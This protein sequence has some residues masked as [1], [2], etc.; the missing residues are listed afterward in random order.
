MRIIVSFLICF[1]FLVST[2]A[3]SYNNEWIDFNKTYYKFPVGSDGIYRISQPSLSTIGLGV[4]PAQNFQ[5]WRNGKEIPLYTS[6]PSGVL[7]SNGYLEFY[8]EMNDGKADKALY[9]Y[10][11]LQIADKW[12]LY[13][14]TA[15]YFLTVNSS[16]A[17]KRYSSISNNVQGNV[18]PPQT[19]FVYT[20][21]KYFRDVMNNGYGVDYGEM[22]YSSSY[23]TGEGWTSQNIAA[24]ASLQMLNSNLYVDHNSADDVTLDVQVAGNMGYLR[25]VRIKLNGTQLAD[26]LVNSY[27]IKRFHITGQPL[28]ILA[29]NNALI[30]VVNGGTGTDKIVVAGYQLTYPRQFNFGG[31]SIFRFN[32][33]AGPEKY[34]EISNF[35]F[36][37]SPPVLLDPV[38]RNRI[39]GD[40]SGS[41]VRFVLPATTA[42]S[43]YVL[44]NVESSNIKYIT[45]FTQRN[46]IDHSLPSMQ[47]NYI[48]ISNPLLFDDGTGHNQVDLYRQYRASAAGGNYQVVVNDINELT[49][50]FAFGIKHHPLAIRNFGYFCMANFTNPP[51]YFLLIGKGLNYKEFRAHESD[52]NISQWA[53]VPTFGYPPSDNL[54]FAQRT[55]S[56]Q[57]VNVGRLSAVTG[58]EVG[59]YLA[60]VKVFEQNQFSG[61]QTIQNKGWMKNVA[62]VT[63]AI[64]D[65]SL[66]ASIN[67]FMAGYA[68]TLVDTF[69]GAKV[70]SFNS[71]SGSY[72]SA[73]SNKTI[74]ELFNGG[75]SF[76]TYFGHSS[77]NTLEFNLDN[78][79]NYSNTG[80]YPLI[81]V[82]GCNTGNLF[83]FDTLRAFNNGTLSEKYVFAKEK[84]SIAFIS[85][86]H[87]GLP[88]QLDYF[89][90]RFNKNLANYMYGSTLGEM[91]RATA[92]YLAINNPNDFATR[93]HA[94][95]ITFH[96]DPAIRLNP[97][98]KPDFVITDSLISI[99]PV[100]ATVADTSVTISVHLFN[101]GKAVSD[102][103]NILVR[104][105][106]PDQ[107]VRLLETRRIPATRYEDVLTFILPVDPVNMSGINKI[108]VSVD[109]ENQV[110]E[111]SESNNTAQTTFEI[112]KD[113]IR[114]VYPYNYAI[115]GNDA[116]LKLYGST[117]NPLEE[118]ETYIMEMDTTR[119]FNSG[120]LIRQSVTDS[121]GIIEFS[122]GVSL[123]DSTVYY[124]RLTT[125]PETG[126]SFWQNSSFTF[127]RNET[128]DGY[129][130]SQFFQHTNSRYND[131]RLDS[132]NRQF[133]FNNKTRKLLIN[134][135]LYPYYLY[136]QIDVNIDND[137]EELYGCVYNSLQFV[138]YNP[139]SLT[140]MKNWNVNATSGR[141]GSAKIC[142][143]S[144]S[145]DDT[146]KF[147]EFNYPTA[148]A[149]E[150]AMNFF[151]SIP[152]GYYV[153]VTNLGRTDN[154]SF[155]DSWKAD[156][157]VLGSGRS[158]WHKFHQMGLHQIDSFTNNKPFLFLF[159][160]GDTINFP[161]RQ[162][163][164][165]AANIHISDTF[166]FP[167]KSVKGSITSPDLGPVKQWKR[168]KWKADPL[169]ASATAYFDLYGID[170]N[171]NQTF[172]RSVKASRD[173]SISFVGATVFPK[174][175]IV[176]NTSDSEN[177]VPVQLKYWMLTGNNYPEGAL[178]PNLLYNCRDT[179]YS[180]DSLYFKVAFKNI[181]DVAF[182]S[183]KLRLTFTSLSG[184]ESLVIDNLQN[185]ARLKPVAPGD[186]AI[187]SYVI[188]LAG[189]PGMNKIKLEVNPDNDQPEQFHFNNVL[190]IPVYVIAGGCIGN[191]VQYAVYP[192][193][194]CNFQWQVNQGA[195]YVN[196]ANAG[197]Y[198]GVTTAQLNISS[199]TSEMAGYRYRCV[200]SNSNEI[201]YSQPFILRFTSTWLGGVSTNWH[202]AGNWSCGVVP[203]TNTDV[204]VKSGT[205]YQP[206]INSNAGCHSLNLYDAATLKIKAGFELQV[207][208]K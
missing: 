195:G 90:S 64:S 145:V 180:S 200:T 10:D 127:I 184:N 150:A 113:A 89:T 191:D 205:T 126:S 65:P 137:K 82:N 92:Q 79:Q 121:G 86:T 72:T 52:P 173:T 203:N 155:I 182:D 207:N 47:G 36:G 188:P 12:S 4:V 29:S 171:Q 6:V 168:F 142:L 76:L 21:Q 56:F 11:S 94:E 42:A 125:S 164:G 136:D 58:K 15:M 119:L 116:S 106:L 38:N 33:P 153:S 27:H 146:R 138:L 177:A 75:L 104:H 175:K 68:N 23:E 111:L 51:Q 147:F 99:S 158:L 96:G 186:T 80:K 178:A 67:F 2:H 196:L 148:S 190:Q 160:K 28:S 25:Y 124:W 102:S 103:I 201:I 170:D 39:V 199:P 20:L 206:V 208:G 163:V 46:F 101:I 132:V 197:K 154:T 88:Q 129:A 97:F 141:F 179:L 134:T 139:V 204:I 152:N 13:T 144:S 185:G 181:S 55:Q 62:Q 59:D 109:S 91:M 60:K 5:L 61:S 105:Q 69:Y 71:N 174:I 70:Y 37:A 31:N 30:E 183:I 162:D 43:N 9:K 194:N 81:M 18:L 156:T 131:M 128:T 166:L 84:G 165:A 133:Q 45:S 44:L 176:M 49:D 100:P 117:A 48:L 57:Q 54:L 22:L 16:S 167:G 73:G 17:N 159:K 24:G 172:L 193:P 93:I 77:P 35:N 130:Q 74:D 122:P 83:L 189:W 8:G 187:I 110:S 3:Q 149:R 7:G 169:N 26:T 192:K 108:M 98:S 19:G 87:F 115:I 107:S 41:I 50:Q 157:A 40:V 14:D 120:L 151:D 1:S 53:L 123:I 114:P 66:A 161:V 118:Q 34:I 202:T 63:G 78:P 32:I 140:P 112:L 143:T 198:S 85:D 135:G 95:E